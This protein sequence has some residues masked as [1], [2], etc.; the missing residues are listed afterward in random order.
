MGVHPT[1]SAALQAEKVRCL[2]PEVC[3]R[4]GHTRCAPQECESF[5][6]S[7]SSGVLVDIRK[8]APVTAKE[9]AATSLLSLSNPMD[10][11]V[12]MTSPTLAID[13]DKVGRVAGR[14]WSKTHTNR[15]FPS[16]QLEFPEPLKNSVPEVLHG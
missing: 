1:T 13:E 14:G 15:G 5:T 9:E 11:L 10:V 6:I 3:P 4:F 16:S 7:G 12:K 8:T 2:C